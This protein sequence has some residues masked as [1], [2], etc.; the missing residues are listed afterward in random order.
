MTVF[1]CSQLKSPNVITQFGSAQNTGGRHVV[2]V[3]KDGCFIDT[4]GPQFFSNFTVSQRRG[5]TIQQFQRGDSGRSR[6][7]AGPANGKLD[8]F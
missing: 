3:A 5:C 6:P 8:F 7:Q 4:D 2:E 1:V